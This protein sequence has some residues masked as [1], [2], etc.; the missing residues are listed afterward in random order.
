MTKQ[1]N[2]K[3]MADMDREQTAR[4]YHRSG[5]NCAISVYGAF[6]DKVSGTPPKP[7]GDGGK[8]G[9]VLAGMQILRECGI[10]ASGFES[11]FLEKYGTIYCAELRKK[12]H[13]CNDLV[14][15]SASMVEN[16]LA[17]VQNSDGQGQI[18]N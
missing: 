6:D 8:C 3:D 4:N 17:R 12:K 7:R 9:T 10:D 5:N 18:I 16:E 2:G 15:F 14:G 11:R 13:P 1:E